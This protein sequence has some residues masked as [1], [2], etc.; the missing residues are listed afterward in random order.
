MFGKVWEARSRLYR[1]QFLQINSKYS[2]ESS[3]RDLPDLH[4]CRPSE[5]NDSN[6]KTMKSAS[7]KRHL[8]EKHSPGEETIRQQQCS[9]ARGNPLRIQNPARFRQTCSHFCSFIFR[10]SL[11]FAIVIQNSSII[12]KI[13]RNCII[14]YGKYQNLIKSPRFSSFLSFR[15]ENCWLFRKW[16][17][18]S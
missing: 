17:S 10:S 12:L 1:S 11:I 7:G 18:K 16:F 15:N 6:L 8:G 2:F 9:E 14:C 4:T 5:S 13:F 3:W